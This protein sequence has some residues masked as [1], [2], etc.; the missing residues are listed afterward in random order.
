MAPGLTDR[1]PPGPP[2]PDLSPEA[3]RKEALRHKAG[4]TEEVTRR[5]GP[6]SRAHEVASRVLLGAWNDG[7]IHAGNL[8]Y[9][10]V[11]AIFPFFITGAALFSL[12]G[13]EGE[14]SAAINT[15]LIA[16]PPV[17]GSVI[18][19]V[20]R[21]VIAQSSGTLLWIGGLV[22]LWTV[23]SLIETIRDI[24]RRAY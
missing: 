15:I 19:P 14:R 20:A 16:L 6:G 7:F 3:R 23:G 22:G 4:L 21:G 18:G 2:L 10:A 1:S 17:V 24:L 13:E 11:L 8:A 9:M 5:V 12:I